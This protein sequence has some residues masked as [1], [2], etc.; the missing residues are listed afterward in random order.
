MKRLG[1]LLALPLAGLVGATCNT[2][3]FTPTDCNQGFWTAVIAGPDQN[4]GCKLGPPAGPEALMGNTGAPS[5]CGATSG[6]ACTDC[7][8]AACCTEGTACADDTACAC[9]MACRAATGG[10]TA[11]CSD[12][13]GATSD[14][15]Y[16][17]ATTCIREDCAAECPRLP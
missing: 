14:P 6:D 4:W 8:N 1:L 17:S 16:V 2:D 11:S 15:A 12:E 3:R 9:L 7:L 5:T 10:T 13:C